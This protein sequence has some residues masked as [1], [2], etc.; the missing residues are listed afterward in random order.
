MQAYERLIRYARIHTTSD[1]NADTTPSAAR[2]FDL[3]HLLE[4]E[5]ISMGFADVMV[6]EHAY[7]YGVVPA[8]EGCGDWPSVGL[9]AHLDTAPD[10]SGALLLIETISPYTG[11]V[12]RLR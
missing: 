11:F 4:E 7:T 10:F 12:E 6:D 8:S 9:I 1:E 3:S 2:Q 5:M